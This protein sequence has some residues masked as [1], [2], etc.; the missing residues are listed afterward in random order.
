MVCEINGQVFVVIVLLLGGLGLLSGAQEKAIKNFVSMDG[1][2]SPLINI[3]KCY[4]T[5]TGRQ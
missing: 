1:G 3:S 5:M 2:R 4:L